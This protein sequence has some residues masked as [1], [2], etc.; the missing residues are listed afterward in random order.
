MSR[1]K[2][3]RPVF[4][5]GVPRSGTTILFEAFAQ[6]KKIGWLSNYSQM[7]PAFHSMNI[8][9]P[10][11]SNSLLGLTGRKKQHTTVKFGNRYLPQPDEAY[12]FWDYYSDHLFSKEYLFDIESSAKEKKQIRKAISNVI[13]WQAK[14]R[15]ATKLTGPSRIKYLRSIFDDAIFIHVIRDGRAV[16]NSLLKVPFWCDGG[17]LENPWWHGGLPEEYINIWSNSHMNSAV[18]AAIQW[19]AIIELARQESVELAP[20]QYLEFRYES[21]VDHPHKTLQNL[22]NVCGLANSRD[23][24]IYIDSGPVL[25]NMN[26]Q[27]HHDFDKND[28]QQITAAMQPLLSDLGYV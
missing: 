26:I 5:I 7:Y 17:G 19:R 27:Y 3:E 25:K 21:F 12:K 18:L 9:R 1:F 6:H 13:R 14:E 28:M 4:F 24:H 8:L 11:L 10:I 23:A 15:F 16:V 2:L 22:Y 20:T